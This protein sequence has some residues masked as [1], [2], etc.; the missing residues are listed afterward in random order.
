M[1]RTRPAYLPARCFANIDE[2]NLC[3]ADVRDDAI[4]SV[5]ACADVAEAR[6][7]FEAWRAASTHRIPKHSVFFEHSERVGRLRYRD[8]YA[9]AIA[10]V[11]RAD[12]ALG[13]VDESDIDELLKWVFGEPTSIDPSVATFLFEL[14]LEDK[15]IEATIGWYYRTVGRDGTPFAGNTSCLPW[16][17]GLRFVSTG[18]RYIGFSVDAGTLSD[19]R[20]PTFIDVQW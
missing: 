10:D 5:S 6:V 4:K 20:L 14:L 17:L 18:S 15:P 7:K 11:L 3:D 16:R 13:G 8:Y 12:A 1:A 9:S 19:A 2:D